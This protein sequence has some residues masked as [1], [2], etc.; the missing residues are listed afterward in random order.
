MFLAWL[1]GISSPLQILLIIILALVFK[2][3]IWEFILVRIGYNSPDEKGVRER[4][5]KE[6]FDDVTELFG[7]LESNHI[8]HVQEAIDR[9]HT[10]QSNM[11]GILREIAAVQR[12]TIEIVKDLKE[13]GI[14]CRKD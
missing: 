7:R 12:D 8:A 1:Q 5:S 13:Y 14:H 9:V 6:W 11:F 2:D 10:N 3:Q 4:S